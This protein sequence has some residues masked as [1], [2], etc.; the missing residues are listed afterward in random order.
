MFMGDI[1]DVV[2]PMIT[3][4]RVE[5]VSFTGS[6]A[7]GKQI[8]HTAGYKKTCL[9]LGGN[10]PLIILDDADLDKAV[11]FAAEG[12]FRNSGQRCTA[13]KRLLVQESIHEEFTKRFVEKAEEY[14]AG[15]PE[16]PATRVGTVIDEAA[17]IALEERVQQA[18]VDGGEI[19]LGG[20]RRGAL[21]E[22]TVINNVPRMTPMVMEE[23][24]GPLA[25]IIPIKDLDDAIDWYNS[26]PFGLSSGV[27]TNNM[28]LALKAV[29]ELR[30]GTT[31]INEV[32][33]YRIESSPFGGVKDSGLGIKEGV[34][35]TM[36]FM[37]NVKTFSLP[38]G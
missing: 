27:V 5:L 25:P 13:V 22:P 16:D 2:T 14:V 20:G 28:E 21:M 8:A 38:W 19:L 23:S 37:S 15:D 29:R 34:I 31:N 35:E 3:D 11:T 24:F 6:V 4:P 33:G 10:S 36:K 7:I 26:G 1:G 12:C 9:E 30:T 32:P 18:V 17:A